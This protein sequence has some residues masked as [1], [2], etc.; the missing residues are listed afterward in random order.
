[1]RCA[2]I[3]LCVGGMSDVAPAAGYQGLLAEPS[4]SGG[5][6]D[7]SDDGCW[8]S[9]A[10]ERRQARRHHRAS[11]CA[12]QRREAGRRRRSP[13]GRD[14]RT[15]T[16]QAALC[17]GPA[18]DRRRHPPDPAVCEKAE[19]RPGSCLSSAARRPM[20]PKW[21]RIVTAQG[22]TDARLRVIFDNGTESNMLM[23][24]L[25]RALHKDEAGRRITDP[26]AGPLF[27]KRPQTMI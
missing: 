27:G 19:I 8:P 4:R 6:E 17:S 10:L 25:Q 7:E 16:V 23:R 22:R 26:V 12:H 18:G 15:S 1:M 13:I 14:A 9:F 20:S 3:A 11:P 2:L 21:A 5:F 24:S